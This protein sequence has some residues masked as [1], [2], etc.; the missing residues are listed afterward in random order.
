MDELAFVQ[1]GTLFRTYG[2]YGNNEKSPN[3]VRETQI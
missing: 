2:V 3:N 1:I